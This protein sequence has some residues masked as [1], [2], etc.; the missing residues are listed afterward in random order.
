MILSQ[1]TVCSF[2]SLS[3]LVLAI[4]VTELND[5][6]IAVNGEERKIPKKGYKTLRKPAARERDPVKRNY[7]TSKVACLGE[8]LKLS[9]SFVDS[10]L[11]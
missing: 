10:F 8:R 2:R 1:V 9:N 4:T 6:A 5:M 3:R 11:L 7:F